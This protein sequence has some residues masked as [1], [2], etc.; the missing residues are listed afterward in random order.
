VALVVLGDEPPRL[1]RVDRWPPAPSG[2][3]K[4]ECRA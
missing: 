2:R 1:T 4:G 3:E